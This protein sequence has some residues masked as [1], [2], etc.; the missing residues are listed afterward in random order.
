[1]VYGGRL[2]LWRWGH[3][4]WNVFGG[5]NGWGTGYSGLPAVQVGGEAVS[6]LWSCSGS[7][8]VAEKPGCIGYC[9]AEGAGGSLI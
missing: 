9:E 8:C 2:A 6:E 7:G 3:G 5:Q 4:L 1:M